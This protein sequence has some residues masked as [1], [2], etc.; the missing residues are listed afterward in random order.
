MLFRSR[1]PP[2]LANAE[3]HRVLCEHLNRELRALPS[4]S[5]R[6]GAVLRRLVEEPA[7]ASASQL[8]DALGMSPRTL[9]RSLSREGAGFRQLRD[10][11]RAEQAR[12]RLDDGRESITEVALTLGFSDSS[13]FARAFRRWFGESPRQCRRNLKARPTKL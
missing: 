11:E 10:R 1:R 4:R 7:N 3:T 2:P 9:R 13:T 6:R 8:A 12:R 5:G